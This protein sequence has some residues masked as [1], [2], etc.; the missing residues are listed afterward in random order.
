MHVRVP[1]LIAVL[2]FLLTL[3]FG[4]SRTSKSITG[5]EPAVLP[6]QAPSL[7]T[8]IPSTPENVPTAVYGHNLVLRKGPDFRIYVRWLRGDMVR[9][10]RDMN[11]TFDDLE[12]FSVEIKTSGKRRG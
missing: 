7:A 5:R 10:R 2:T 11:P 3:M 9:T 12:A 8:R 1:I 4:H 6:A